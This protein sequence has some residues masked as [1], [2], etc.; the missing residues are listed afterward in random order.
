LRRKQI[1]EAVF[2]DGQAAAETTPADTD[3]GPMG[4]KVL[5]AEDNPV[6]AM[7]VRIYLEKLGCRGI[8]V[9]NGIEAV[10]M[11]QQETF[12]AILMDCQ[13]PLMDG[14]EATR[15]IRSIEKATHP[16]LAPVRIIAVTANALEG[17]RTRCLETG[18]DDYI[19]KPFDVHSLMDTLQTAAVGKNRAA[20]N[21]RAQSKVSST[22]Y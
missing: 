11:F 17:E 4:I 14:Y 22:D 5:V 21:T 20:A 10:E 19:S 12:D 1:R 18:M 8:F 6:N 16:G 2:P 3:I 15:R 7:V 13:M 9:G